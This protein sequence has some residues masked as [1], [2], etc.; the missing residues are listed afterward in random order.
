V[1]RTWGTRMRYA[2]Q[3]GLMVE[4]QN[5]PALLMAGFTKF[6]PQNSMLR[7]WWES[8]VARGVIAKGAS[9]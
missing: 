8:E 1:S 3:S 7:F 9:R 2:T 4:P 5:H 6:G